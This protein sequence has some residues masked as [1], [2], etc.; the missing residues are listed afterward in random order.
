MKN[1]GF[2]ILAIIIVL[3]LVSFLVFNTSDN[4]DTEFKTVELKEENLIVNSDL[5]S[6][7]DTILNVG[8]EV[9]G[10]KGVSVNVERLSDEA[11]R[12]FSGELNAH[13]RYLNGGFYLFIDPLNKKQA[14]TIISHEIVHMK[15]YLDGRFVYDDGS[16][17]WNGDTYLL[18]EINYDNRPWESEAFEQESQLASQ[19]SNIIYQ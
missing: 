18:D 2:I 10:I 5:P 11:K 6:F 13:V 19:I 8:L 9:A 14:L 7:Y 4:N 3:G 12:N 15:Q 1:N 16:I 17:L